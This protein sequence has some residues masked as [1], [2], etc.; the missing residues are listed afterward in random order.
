MRLRVNSTAHKYTN[1]C[2]AKVALDT[3]IWPC[4]HASSQGILITV[5]PAISWVTIAGV[6]AQLQLLHFQGSPTHSC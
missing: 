3:E 4:Q 6:V 1:I 2:E 5:L